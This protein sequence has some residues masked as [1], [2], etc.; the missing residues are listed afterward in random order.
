LAERAWLPVATAAGARDLIRIRDIAR[1]DILRIDTGR[2][3]C[4]ISVTEFLI[5]LLA[6][7]AL[8]PREKRDWK[9]RFF[10]PPTPEEIDAAI[11][12]FAHALV[13]D[14]PGPRFFQDLEELTDD[15]PWEIER[16][17]INSP[18][19]QTLK[20]NSDHFVKRNTYKKFSRAG[21]AI[22]LITLQTYAPGGGRGNT[23]S[24][25][26][27]SGPLTTLVRPSIRGI[28]PNLWQILWCNT[29]DGYQLADSEIPKAFPW[30]KPT[31]LSVDGALVVP[32]EQKTH[33]AL[34]FFA[35]PRRIRI[36]FSRNEFKV[37]CDFIGNHDEFTVQS[38]IQKPSGEKYKYWKHPLSPYFKKKSEKH[39]S[40]QKFDTGHTAYKQWVSLT[41]GKGEDEIKAD[42]VASFSERAKQLKLSNDQIKI[43]ASGYIMDPKL[44]AKALDF[45]EAYL[46][47]ITTSTPD[48]D[49]D[50][51]FVA[52]I[53]IEAADI[54]ARLL[55]SSLKR[56]LFGNSPNIDSDNTILHTAKMR[57]WTGT[58]EGFYA[59]LG[60]AAKA[61]DETGI[62]T[63]TKLAIYARWLPV[64][65]QQC[66]RIFD[67]IAP[68]DAPEDPDI[69]HVVAGRTTLVLGL[70][71]F[72]K[73]GSK[74]FET[75][76]IP[77]PPQKKNGKK[78]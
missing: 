75:L 13:L 53:L 71:G 70:N 42:I 21:A 11:A 63:E 34:A 44:P 56:S 33:Q 3:D 67:D 61:A 54:C 8:A 74:L 4:D 26:G 5:G 62:A 65:R 48:A 77:V 38:Y 64:T 30:L 76:G 50:L 24:L 2:P 10:E 25:R 22:A 9:P 49:S 17:F 18:G 45:N 72:G 7:S 68:V 40:P 43:W 23:A 32:D 1:P 69:E 29:P 12:P 57:F 39:F 58:E 73:Q 59:L 20:D 55:S 51:A 47:I 16:L 52:K 14:G 15:D 6:I 35:M 27:G 78:K 37:N 19:E 46:P 31:R 66:E 60:D 36:L 28:E 41:L